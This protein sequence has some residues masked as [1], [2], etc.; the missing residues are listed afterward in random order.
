MSKAWK[1]NFVHYIFIVFENSLIYFWFQKKMRRFCQFQILKYKKNLRA[2]FFN[3]PFLIL[4][5][6]YRL[7]GHPGYEIHLLCIKGMYS[8]HGAQT[9]KSYL[10]I[11]FRFNLIQKKIILFRQTWADRYFLKIINA[12]LLAQKPVKW[13]I[14]IST[15]E[16]T[17][18]LK[19]I[20]N[21]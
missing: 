5:V 16:I 21:V 19:K 4:M 18:I 20:S 7:T 3:R 1:F 14:M 12:G 2:D 8:K 9:L 17:V 11:C 6:N 13:S 15:F 10:K